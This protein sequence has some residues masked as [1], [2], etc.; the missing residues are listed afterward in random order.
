MLGDA[1]LAELCS[2]EE[3][4]AKASTYQVVRELPLSR[5]QQMST[6]NDSKTA[7]WSLTARIEGEVLLASNVMFR[8]CKESDY[9]T[10]WA[11]YAF[12][13]AEAFSNLPTPYLPKISPIASMRRPLKN[14]S[15][16]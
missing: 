14:V 1:T 3:I 2:N 4:F 7:G 6:S 13:N 9:I 5:A 10:C 12:I 8:V 11:S 16:A 15:C